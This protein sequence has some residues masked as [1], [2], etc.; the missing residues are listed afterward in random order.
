MRRFEKAINPSDSAS[1]L[2]V[3]QNEIA[4]VLV[5]GQIYA[6]AAEAA[7]PGD[8][9]ISI[10]ASN[11]T[12]GSTTGGAAGVGRVLVPD[13]TWETVTASGALGIIRIA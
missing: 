5:R 7:V 8:N 6:T 3:S 2:A 13:A 11:G 10:T 4:T 1:T 9:V 12:L